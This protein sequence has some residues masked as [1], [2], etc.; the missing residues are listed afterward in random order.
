MNVFYLP[1]WN[2]LSYTDLEIQVYIS[3]AIRINDKNRLSIKHILNKLFID[4]EKLDNIIKELNKVYSDGE[5]IKSNSSLE[6]EISTI[7]ENYY[8][9]SFMKHP[10]FQPLWQEFMDIRKKKKASQTERA[11]KSLLK[12][13]VDFSEGDDNKAIKI[14][15]RSCDMGWKD[16]FPLREQENKDTLIKNNNA[17]LNRSWNL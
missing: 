9:L 5:I 10:N 17:F 13:L 14:L 12:R 7:I 15:E 8:N 6:F 11:I 2:K 3:E 16:V 4:E 1:S